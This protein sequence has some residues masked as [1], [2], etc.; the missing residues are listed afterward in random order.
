MTQPHNGSDDNV[1][2]H[3]SQ[4]P[5]KLTSLSN[6]DGDYNHNYGLG[7][8]STWFEGEIQSFVIKH[9]ISM[10]ISHASWY[11]SLEFIVW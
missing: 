7:F 1:L 3:F 2:V 11:M 9:K 8:C 10:K 4:L 5:Q 6:L